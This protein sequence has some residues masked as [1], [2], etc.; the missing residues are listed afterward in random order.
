MEEVPI[1]Q[2]SYLTA[3][4]VLKCSICFALEADEDG[5]KYCLADASKILGKESHSFQVLSERSFKFL[6]TAPDSEKEALATVECP[7][8]LLTVDEKGTPRFQGGSSDSEI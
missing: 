7:L 2:D 3:D 4:D 5:D 1:P 8:G 6:A